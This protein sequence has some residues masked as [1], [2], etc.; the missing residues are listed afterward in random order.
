[1][2][3]TIVKRMGCALM[4]CLMAWAAN[5][6]PADTASLAW[7]KD[8]KFGLFLHWGLYSMLG[9]GEWTMTVNNI[10]YL[11]YAKLANAFFV[12]TS[13][14]AN[15]EVIA[16]HHDVATFK[17]ARCCD[18]LDVVIVEETANYWFNFVLFAIARLSTRIGNNCAHAGDNS[19]VFYEACVRVFLQSRKNSYVNTAL[20]KSVNI[21]AVLFKRALIDWLAE[22]RC[23]CDAVAKRFAR[24]A[25]N[26]VAKF[27]HDNL[28]IGFDLLL[29][30]ELIHITLFVSICNHRLLYL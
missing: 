21:V 22:L 20:F 15:I 26:Y 23:A 1:M 4:V 7:F 27:S 12:G 30:D 14:T 6:Q 16:N 28:S 9:T 3:T 24:A 11:E 17:R 25:H 29:F 8:A 2:K 10:N 13:R 18:V 5:A 19:R